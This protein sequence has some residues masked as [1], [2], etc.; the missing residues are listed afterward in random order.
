M[1]ETYRRKQAATTAAQ[2]PAEIE[3]QQLAVGPA[4]RL[5]RA[6]TARGEDSTNLTNRTPHEAEIPEG[7]LVAE[8]LPW[9]NQRFEQG[10]CRLRFC[11]YN[12][13]SSVSSLAAGRC[14]VQRPAKDGTDAHSMLG[15]RRKLKNQP[16]CVS[17]QGSWVECAI[18][19]SVAALRV[20]YTGLRGAAPENPA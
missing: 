15:S 6:A 2:V 3:R 14:G 1:P 11:L 12:N 18:F 16:S 10:T 19:L 8:R 13:D 5:V 9:S 4:D 20:L 17:T 7:F